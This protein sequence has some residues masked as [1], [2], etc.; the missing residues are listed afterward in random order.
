MSFYS[1]PDL[2]AHHAETIGNKPVYLY[3]PPRSTTAVSLSYRALHD[4]T[5]M[6]AAALHEQGLRGRNALL[7][8][9]PGLDFIQA[10]FGCLRGSV[11][12]IPMYIPSR[13]V[14]DARLR[15]IAET[16]EIAAILT[17]KA[18]EELACSL[19]AELLPGKDCRVICTDAMPDVDVSGMDL[20]VDIEVPP[21]IQFTSGSTARPKGVVVSHAN[22]MANQRMI[23][24]A[25]SHQG[26]ETVV[27]WLPFFHD[28]GLIGN[29]MQPLYIGGSSVLMSP[30]DFLQNPH[31]WLQL[32]SMHAA[33]TSGAPN[34][35]YDYCASRVTEEQ[36]E[37]LDLSSWVVA[38]NGSEMIRPTTMRRFCD[39]FKAHG[40]RPEAVLHCY[41]MAETTLYVSSGRGYL[42]ST[43]PTDDVQL[44]EIAS[45]GRPDEESEVC[46]V[47]EQGI[48]QPEGCT[49]EIWVRGPHVALGYVNNPQATEVTF[50]AR[51]GGCQYAPTYLRTGDLGY[52]RNG[53]LHV[54]G[55]VKNLIVVNGKN[56]Y[57]EEIEYFVARSDEYFLESGACI[58]HVNEGL[59]NNEIVF[60]QEIRKTSFEAASTDL[61]R[62]EEKALQLSRQILEH[63]NLPVHR[64]I[65]LRESRLPRTS[66]GKVDRARA[67]DLALAE[68]RPILLE[69]QTR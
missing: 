41:G 5:C 27:S 68:D 31:K 58:M 69:V 67:R 62:L 32:I 50:H 59:S 36:A 2:L 39:R 44:D 61:K 34:F 57:G 43:L 29:I 52:L 6:L 55:R 15:A 18:K 66:S 53:E 4:A 12:T 37:E 25:F 26:G 24:R 54:V 46:I 20:R 9:P 33:N 60:I 3:V 11:S 13:N 45:V 8:Y 47:D 22:I 40:F 21:L 63:F 1:L 30:T 10:F 64:F 35:A 19:A 65:Y 23:Q 7:L 28:M 56:Y 17:V 51:P 49:G 48:E 14:P 38:Y 42:S 16:V